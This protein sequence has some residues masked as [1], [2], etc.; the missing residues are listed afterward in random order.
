MNGKIIVSVIAIIAAVALGFFFINPT[1]A[2]VLDDSLATQEGVSS[3]VDANNKF[4]IDLYSRYKGDEGNIFFS[5]YSISTALAMTYE[6]ARGQTAE[7]MRNVLYFPEDNDTRRYS[8][9]RIQ[10]EMNKR[11]KRY[12]LSTANALWAQKDYPFLEEYFS[13]MGKHYDAKITNLDFAGE[14]ETSRITINSWVE[15][16]TNNKI[17][18][19]IPRDKLGPDIMLVLTNAIYF[20]G[21]WLKQFDKKNTMEKD[22]RASP[23][24]TVKAQM[25][26]LNGEEAVF[27][28]TETDE[29]QVLELPYAGNE[30]SMIVLLPKGDD[31]TWLED[32][33]ST[34]NLTAWRSSLMQQKVNVFMPK[35]KFETK[36]SMGNTL[37]KM[38][39]PAAFTDPNID[40][41]GADFSG[42][43]GG[44]RLFIGFVIHQAYVDVNEEGTEAAAATAVGMGVTA[45][46]PTAT[47]NADHPFIFIIQEK[48]TGNI[49]FMGR[50]SNP[51]AQ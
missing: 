50:V 48:K 38:G 25:M 15:G 27:N 20:K 11:D 10:N 14:T 44:K 24:S 8:F 39:M 17:K 43:D 6:G 26:S 12:Q 31:L 29:L 1:S 35:F 36:Y 5:P 45:Y 9:A 16:K 40:P 19:L 34:D 47:F 28:Y 46:Q 3:V 33:I 21:D 18:D 2:V 32:S 4:A 30:L 41:N 13:L 49:L 42:M 23:A 7:E 37:K 51:V 22:F